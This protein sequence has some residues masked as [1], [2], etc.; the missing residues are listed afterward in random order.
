MEPR[1]PSSSTQRGPSG[2]SRLHELVV[3]SG[4]HPGPPPRPGDGLLT[5]WY[6][7]AGARIDFAEWCDPAT[8]SLAAVL[9]SDADLAGVE[10]AVVAFAQAR[11][12]S[13]HTAPEVAD[14]LVALVRVSWRTAGRGRTRRLD[15]LALLARALGA[16]AAERVAVASAVDCVDP[17]TGLVTARFLERRL[18]ELHAQCEALAIAPRMTF[19][20]LVVQ[21]ELSAV[22][23]PERIGVRVAAGRILGDR[24]R[25]GE[26]VAALG[27]S[28][29][30]SRL[31]AVMPA[32]GVDRAMVE[33]LADL[34]ELAQVE[35][36]E[37]TVGRVPFGNHAG[38]TFAALADPTVA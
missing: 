20:S 11:A 8:R 23:A 35:G 14:D 13:D 33:V 1:A 4:P 19:A 30:A 25:A 34:G 5:D 17:V 18:H 3:R 16:W 22:A 31:V 28:R 15:S 26:T 24:F 9:A 21:L 2:V 7:E 27:S 38:A 6:L 36:V 32:Y 37:V 12:G 10:E 29:T